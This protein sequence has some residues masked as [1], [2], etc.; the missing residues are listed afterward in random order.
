M[1]ALS[2]LLA[3]LAKEPAVIA[4][5]VA[6]AIVLAA[7]HFGILLDK[8]TITSVLTPIVLGAATRF[9]VSPAIKPPVAST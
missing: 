9:A 1:N 7:G 5:F 4:G 6:A 3:L 8:P 2:P